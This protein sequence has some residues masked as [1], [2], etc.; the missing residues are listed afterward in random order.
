M[1]AHETGYDAGRLTVVGRERESAALAS[2]LRTA[3]RDGGAQLVTGQPGI[4]KTELLKA[5]VQQ[6]ASL[7]AR[8]LHASGSEYETELSFAGLH[9]LLLP[10]AD[11]LPELPEVHRAALATALGFERGDPPG[12]LVLTS[13]LLAWLGHLASTTPLVLVVDDLQWVDRASVVILSLVA[14]RLG[15]LR[16]GLLLS[17]RTGQESFFDRQSVPELA[18]T[19]LEDDAAQSLLRRHHPHLHASVRHRILAEAD[20]NPL[21]LIELPRALTAAQETGADF[22]PP[23]LPLSARLRWLFESRVSHL[24]EPTRRLLLLAALGSEDSTPLMKVVAGC[25]SDLAPAEA[26]ALVSV[27]RRA[28]RLRFAHPLIR[29]AVV[30]LATAPERRAAHHRLAQLAADP[31]VRTL[32]LAE[33]ALG[34]DDTIAARLVE[35]ALT[36]LERGDTAQ[37]VSL[38]LRAADMSVDPAD[39]A[40]RLVRAAYIGANIAGTL[41][42]ARALLERAREADP[43]VTSTLRASTAAAAH[44]LNSDGDIDTA[45]QLLVGAVTHVDPDAQS[46]EALEEAL[47]TLMMICAFGGRRELWKPFD[48]AVTRLA[49]LLTA[50]FRLAATTFADPARSTPEHLRELDALLADLDAETN[51]IRAVMVA[52]AGHYVDRVPRAA[53]ERTAAEGRAGGAVA[54][55]VQAVIMLAAGA[56]HEGRW[57]DAAALADEGIALCRENG[58]DLLLWGAQN[59]QMLLAAARADLDHIARARVLMHQW[60]IPRNALAVRTFTANIEGLA[61]LSQARYQD[62]YEHYTSI[63]PLGTF[64][65]HEQVSVWTIMDAVEAAVGSGHV[66]EARAHVRAASEAGLARISPRLRFLC[67]AAAALVADDDVYPDLFDPLVAH[68]ESL[69]WPFPLARLE[70]AYGERLRRDRAMRAARP[71]L[72]RAEKLFTSLGATPWADRAEA[73]LRATGRSRRSAGPAAVLTPQERQIAELAATGLTNRQIGEQLQLSPRTVGAHL[74]R[75]FPKLGI[76]SR[77]ALRDALTDLGAEE[78]GP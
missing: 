47:G 76:S 51:P 43:A 56:F 74:Y 59:P 4:G 44:L 40:R 71:H 20:G 26:S 39:R 68:P 17:Q 49:P 18:L 35:V 55:A 36:T 48:D 10:A 13:A 52:L 32:H 53:L 62:A 23:T 3:V 30:D 73:A 34:P 15:G 64:P 1:A 8:V 16:V 33:S 19:P 58:Y 14:R 63:C 6:S 46:A 41:D 7:G 57:Q 28:D 9:Q 61:A 25:A 11:S 38:L 21:A 45:H 31:D 27:D 22:L 24:P 12:R 72:E 2:F 70:L 42:G 37:A 66:D 29:S 50:P 65:S 77:A 67:A 78:N 60:A 54:L 5:A 69:R 75:V